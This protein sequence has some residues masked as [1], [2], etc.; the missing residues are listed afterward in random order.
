MPLEGLLDGRDGALAH[1]G[2]A[3]RLVDA[4]P[5]LRDPLAGEQQQP[6]RRTGRRRCRRRRATATD[7]ED[8]ADDAEP[9]AQQTGGGRPSW[10]GSR[11]SLRRGRRRGRGRRRRRGRGDCGGRHRR[12]ARRPRRSRS[13]TR[14]NAADT[15]A[16]SSAEVTVP[17]AWR[18]A[19]SVSG[20]RQADGLDVLTLD[21]GDGLVERGGAAVVL[22]V[23][24]QHE[25]LVLGGRREVLAGGDHDVVE[26]GVAVGHDPVD[27]LAEQRAVGRRRCQHRDVVAERLDADAD[28]RRHR[29]DELV[30]RRLG[31]VDGRP[32]APGRVDREHDLEVARRAPGRRRLAR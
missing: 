15:P 21:G 27:L 6:E 4:Q 8:D 32:H 23:R 24:Q 26:R 12:S 25:H 31:G 9:A 30:G 7:D 29:R 3:A 5:S 20:G 22:A 10:P 14:A 28:V 16:A 17:R 19:R 1:V 2:H 11:P 18:L 13:A